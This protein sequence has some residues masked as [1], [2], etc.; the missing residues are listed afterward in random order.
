MLYLLSLSFTVCFLGTFLAR[1]IAIETKR[2]RV[3][4]IINHHTTDLCLSFNFDSISLIFFSVVSLIS[5]VVFLYRKFYIG[6]NPLKLNI[7]N[8]YFFLVL[9]MFVI[10][11]FFLVFSNS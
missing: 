4:I 2:I 10:S 3:E 6:H 8:N 1:V 9:M 5:R 11:I 7:S